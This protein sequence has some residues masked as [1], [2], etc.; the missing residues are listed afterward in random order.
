[1]L[2]VAESKRFSMQQVLDH[3]YFDT[4]LSEDDYSKG[5]DEWLSPAVQKLIDLVR[6]EEEA[7][8]KV[9]DSNKAAFKKMN[10]ACKEYY[11]NEED[12]TAQNK[13][14][15]LSAKLKEYF[16]T[17]SEDKRDLFYKLLDDEKVKFA[18]H[19]DEARGILLSLTDEGRSEFLSFSKDAYDQTVQ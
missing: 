14:I 2:L 10:D 15:K 4:A 6:K 13:F 7:L 9:S 5:Y 18:T 3:R 11:L 16:L 8:S 1:M 17:V 19:S 12:E